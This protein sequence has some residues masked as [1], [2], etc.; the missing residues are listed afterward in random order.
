MRERRGRRGD[1]RGRPVEET[2]AGGLVVD[3]G[4]AYP[5]AALIGRRGR[6]GEIKWSLPKGHLEAGETPAQAAVREIAE[7][8]GIEG[9]VVREI[10]V[11]DYWFSAHD[12]PIH[13]T[14]HHFLLTAI[15]G[16]LHAD[17]VEVDVTAWV[18]LA[19]VV[20]QLAFPNERTLVAGDPDLLA[21]IA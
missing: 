18:S 21:E 15:G 20:G 3:R 16:A 5:R 14:V 6:D 4:G 2:S 17:D 9:R 19:D 13:K 12:H 8:T 11:I 1:G 10:G 7:E